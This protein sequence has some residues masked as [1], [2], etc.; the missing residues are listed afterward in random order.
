[1]TSVKPILKRSVSTRY[2]ITKIRSF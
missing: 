1:V 2:K